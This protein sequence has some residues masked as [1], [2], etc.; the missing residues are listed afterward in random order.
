MFDVTQRGEVAVLR[1]SHGKANTIDVEFCQGITERLEEIKNSS[2]KALVLTGER[3]I[4]SAG[5]DLTRVLEEGGEYL[6]SLAPVLSGVFETLFL[7]PKPVVA[8]V[9]GHAIAGGCLLVCT[10]DHRIM[11]RGTGRIGTPELLLGVPL[12]TIALEI[13]R[14]VTNSQHLQTMLYSGATYLPEDAA[15]RGLVDEL[16]EPTDL[17]DKAVEKAEK[18]TTI[19]PKVFEHTKRHIRQPV[20][21]RVRDRQSSFEQSVLDMW[22][23]P[24]TLEAIRNYVSRTLKKD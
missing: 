4:F 13:M 20:L 21:E 12:P 22:G 8:A 14:F 24:E 2:S 7:Y 1:M 6:Q 17:L 11:A 5:L 19:S 23:A 18:L 3:N 9:N 15:G 16:V 10:A